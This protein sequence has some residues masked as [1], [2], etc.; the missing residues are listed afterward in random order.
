[1]NACGRKQQKIIWHCEKLATFDAVRRGRKLW[2]SQQEQTEME[3]DFIQRLQQREN[4]AYVELYDCYFERLQRLAA[5]YVFDMDTA[6]DIVQSALISLYEH[7][8]TLTPEMNLGAYLAVAV[9]NA[10]LNYLRDRQ[11]ED[12]HKIL[13]LQASEQA[14]ALDWLDDEELI[15]KVKST[16]ASLPGKYREICELRFY[17]NLRY[18]EIAARLDITETAAKVQ[19]HR[20]IQKIKDA[21]AGKD[22]NL[23]GLIVFYEIFD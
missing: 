1:M 5:N 3:K 9:R 12:R 22:G 21:L 18:N 7:V 15:A 6:K 13:Y 19:V 20:A 8:D 14:D 10:C 23:I 17:E 2:D 16:I 4:R 11:V